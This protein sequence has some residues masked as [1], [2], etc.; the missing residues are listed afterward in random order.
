MLR[1]SSDKKTTEIFKSSQHI[2]T[3]IIEF[4]ELLLISRMFSKL[5]CFDIFH[6]D[7]RE[8]FITCK[9]TDKLQT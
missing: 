8:M 5:Y 7:F 9:D 4:G 6:T 1:L 2:Y 3:F